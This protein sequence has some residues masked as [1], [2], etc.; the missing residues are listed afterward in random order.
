MT[1][2]L[3]LLICMLFAVA[4]AQADELSN[5]RLDNWH[6]WRGPDANGLAPRGNPPVEWNEETNIK[7]KVSVPGAGSATP[8]VW[9]DQ[10]FILS[11]IKTDRTKPAADKAA[12]LPNQPSNSTSSRSVPVIT[13][14]AL[15]E[16]SDRQRDRDRGNR[17]RR[18]GRRRRGRRSQAPTNFYKFQV[19]SFDRNT[20]D[21]QWQQTAAEVVPHE[22][23]HRDNGFASASP[24]TDGKNLYASFGSRGIYSYDLAGKF[25]WKR[26]LGTMQTRNGF[27]EGISPVVSGDNLIVLWD[28]EGDSFLFNLDANTG[29]TRW[30]VARDEASAWTTPLI[31]EQNGQTQVVV[32]GANRVRSY[33]LADGELL[34][35]CGGQT[36]NVIPS[37][38]V[39]NGNVI[40]MSGWRGTAAYAIPLDASG[41]LTDS[42]DFSWHYGEGTP[43]VPSPLLY[44]DQIYFTRRNSAILTVLDAQTGEP[45]L[46]DKR[47]SG[48]NGIYASLVGAA[49]RVYLVGRDGTTLVIKHA[50]ELEIL[51][52]NKLDDPIDASPAIVGRQMFLR[53]QQ[54]LYC[55]AA[56]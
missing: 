51:A 42:K 34:W 47:L 46:K 12:E 48:L 6:Q 17:G 15:Q 44:G 31:V 30:K 33:N 16:N 8:I 7:W 35:E 20:G 36:G 45:I 1:R 26:M 28:H 43:Y 24:M 49:D 38:V 14:S 21:I 53:G 23:H 4:T 55:I 27:G 11:A 39:S 25:R 18:G 56:D 19:I 9:K 52:T 2:F 54:H 10:V 29:K 3:L 13:V 41:D 40:C 50:P 32:N 22:G 5:G 37:P